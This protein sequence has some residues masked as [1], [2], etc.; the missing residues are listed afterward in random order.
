MAKD[1]PKSAAEP[2]AMLMAAA[3][4]QRVKSSRE[5]VLA[6]YQSIQGKTLRPT[7]SIRA[8]KRRTLPRVRARV[9]T[10]DSPSPAPDTAPLEPTPK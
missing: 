8:M 2:Y 10:M 1:T 5:P 6:T 3:M 9:V 4:T 7:M